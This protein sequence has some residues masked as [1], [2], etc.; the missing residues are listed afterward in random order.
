RTGGLD[1]PSAQ[2]DSGTFDEVAAFKKFQAGFTNLLGRSG[3]IADADM[4]AFAAFMLQVTYPPNPIRRLDNQ[5][6]PSQQAG[7]DFF[8]HNFSDLSILGTCTS[9]HKL[10]PMR[11]RNTAW[12]R[13]ASSAPMAAILGM[14]RRKRSKRRTSATFTRRSACSG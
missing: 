14:D 9:C 5:L 10:D 6:T 13:Q 4:E 11:T 3:P 12:P 1:N 2:P 8:L 7:R